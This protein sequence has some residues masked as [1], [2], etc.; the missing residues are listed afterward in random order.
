M[1]KSLDTLSKDEL[2]DTVLSQDSEIERLKHQVSLFQKA[3]FGPKNETFKQPENKDQLAISFEEK[4]D[5][6]LPQDLPTKSISYNRKQS[7][8]TDYSK[9]EIPADLERVEQV[10]EPSD[11]TEDMVRI[12]EDVTELIAIAPQRF[13]VKKIIRPKYARANKEGIAIAELPSRPVQG[14]KVDVSF[15]VTI[16]M[17]KY[18]DHLPLHRQLKR[19]ERLGIKISDSTIGD[20][21]AEGMKLLEYLY[22]ELIKVVKEGKYLQADE[23]RIQVL[24]KLLKGKT[25]RGYYWVYHDVASG[26]VL[27]DYDPGRGKSPPQ[28]FLSE[29]N[30]VI[31]V[32]GYGVYENLGN[33]NITIA[34]C[35]AH[36]RRYF[37]DALSDNKIGAEWMLE[38]IKALYAIEDQARKENLDHERRKQLRQ[39]QSIPVLEEMEKWLK[40]KIQG[41]P[42]S[43][44]LSKAMSYMLKRWDKL[45]YF[46][47]DGRIEIDNNLVENSIRPI[48]LGRKNYLFAGSHESARRAGIMYSF[49]TC[50]KKNGYDPYTWLTETLSKI[51]DMKPSEIHTLLPLKKQDGV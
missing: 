14:G 39:E 50:C 5:L 49:L 24:D 41:E 1:K 20:W 46:T 2:I 28:T 22:I 25:H 11:K 45:C 43:L 13:Y 47:K 8:R 12:G 27:Y 18:L 26:L 40:E 36:A 6:D 34:C 15:L 31:Q 37:F 51:P 23:T 16:L 21:A 44:P 30:G 17:D 35:M 3:L 29:Y 19:Y 32:D 4:I 9:F 42:P 38:K 10:I 48:A 7:K 33:K